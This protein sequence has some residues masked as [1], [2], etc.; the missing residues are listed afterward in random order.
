MYVSILFV[1]HTSRHAYPNSHIWTHY[2]YLMDRPDAQSWA[3]GHVLKKGGSEEALAIRGSQASCRNISAQSSETMNMLTQHLLVKYWWLMLMSMLTLMST[4]VSVLM[5]IMFG[6]KSQHSIPVVSFGM[7]LLR[8]TMIFVMKSKLHKWQP[9]IVLL[10]WM[11]TCPFLSLG[12]A[13]SILDPLQH[14]NYKKMGFDHSLKTFTVIFV[15]KDREGK[16][17]LPLH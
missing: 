14:R 16:R 5:L 13:C 4:L 6:A 2:C 17:L 1:G 3:W 9:A 11:T 10:M 8:D 7:L 15:Q 12:T